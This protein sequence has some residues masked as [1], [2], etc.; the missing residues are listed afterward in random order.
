[1]LFEAPEAALF[2]KVR[3]ACDISQVRYAA[4]LGLGRH[5]AKPT[6]RME[7]NSSGRS[8]ACFFHTPGDELIAKSCK[9][10]DYRTLLKILPA[11]VAHLEAARQEAA[12]QRV[13]SRNRMVGSSPG[14]RQ[15]ASGGIYGLSGSLLPRYLGLY[16][17]EVA[18]DTDKVQT[19]RIV[20]MINV[21][22]G[23]RPIHRK[24]DLKGSTAGRE[25]TAKERKKDKPVWL[26]LDWLRSE[27]RLGIGASAKSRL[28]G[29]LE[30]DVR[31]LTKQGLIDYSLLV[32]VHDR[33]EEDDGRR[34][35]NNVVYV[36]DMSH[37]LAYI[38][39]VD[40]LTPYGWRK[41]GETFM[42]GTLMGGIDIS[43]Q[44]PDVYGERFLS[45]LE[46]KVFGEA[47]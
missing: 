8:G 1:M 16:R 38:G 11:Y 46:S 45:F 29:T 47:E 5:E 17:F 6:L 2:A 34:E 23:A 33:K 39:M 4:M 28:M 25:A 3:A 19:V 27:R 43:C 41:W 24:Y 22:G 31:F 21:F 32:G 42:K 35:V 40:V 36:E 26:D 9:P 20:V 14:H 7:P 44:P 12:F 13:P 30:S 37:R 10:E 15:R 18:S